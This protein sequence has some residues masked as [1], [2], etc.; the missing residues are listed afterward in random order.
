[1]SG[2]E[3]DSERFY[4]C[5]WVR[6]ALLKTSEVWVH[7]LHAADFRSLCRPPRNID[8]TAHPISSIIAPNTHVEW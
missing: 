1:M 6:V 8:L 7:F 3:M 2:S 4:T 5:F